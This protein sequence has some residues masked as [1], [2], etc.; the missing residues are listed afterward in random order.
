M[1][2]YPFPCDGDIIIIHDRGLSDYMCAAY[3]TVWCIFYVD[4]ISLKIVEMEVQLQKLEAGV[5]VLLQ[6]RLNGCLG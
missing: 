3:D 5:C 2:L 1:P 4:R 6:E